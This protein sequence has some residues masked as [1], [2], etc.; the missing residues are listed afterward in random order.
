VSSWNGFS[1]ISS[2]LLARDHANS[3]QE[4]DIDLCVHS[5]DECLHGLPHPEMHRMI[6][7]VNAKRDED[8]NAAL[9]LA[10]S[11]GCLEAACK[12]SAE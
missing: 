3:I 2:S 5:D 10:S 8:G 9:I 7:G 6:D 1:A 11:E 12:D 4:A